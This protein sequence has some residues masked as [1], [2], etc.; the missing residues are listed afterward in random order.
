[1]FVPGLPVPSAAAGAV[2]AGPSTARSASTPA[3]AARQPRREIR[4]QSASASRSSASAFWGVQR[5][6]EPAVRRP[7]STDALHAPSLESAPTTC[8]VQSARNNDVLHKSDDG[9]FLVRLASEADL[10][11]IA[12]VRANAF[13]KE[14]EADTNEYFYGQTRDE[15]RDVV[16]QRLTQ[17]TIFI[18]VAIDTRPSEEPAV[19]P[20]SPALVVGTAD[21]EMLAARKPA[22][23]DPESLPFR[24]YVSNMSVLRP[25]RRRGLGRLLLRG[26]EQTAIEQG[27]DHLYLHVMEDNEGALR[28][29]ER[30]GFSID[31]YESGIAKIL[32]QPRRIRMNKE[33]GSA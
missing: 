12:E 22:L 13:F 31:K 32:S 27:S 7:T 4:P 3:P 29:Y 1:M 9:R 18:L 2:V 5:S 30:S 8:E 16:A 14:G 10:D 23:W 33:C 15:F 20:T 24:G 26:C 17:P 25:Y 28:A 19:A 21:V 6:F 11:G